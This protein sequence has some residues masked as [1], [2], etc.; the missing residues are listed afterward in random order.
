MF[1]ALAAPERR[2]RSAVAILLYPGITAL[3]A[4]GPWEVLSR[5]SC[6]ASSAE[7]GPGL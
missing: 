6:P 2:Q 7:T 4:V 3:N 1:A 5:V